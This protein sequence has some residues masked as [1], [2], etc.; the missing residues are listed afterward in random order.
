MAMSTANYKK[1]PHRVYYVKYTYLS[2]G[3]SKEGTSVIVNPSN[4]DDAIEKA[5][6]H[7]TVA[8]LPGFKIWVEKYQ[9]W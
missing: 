3:E 8:H 6:K 5:S 7:L 1:N 4:N 2:Q 9:D